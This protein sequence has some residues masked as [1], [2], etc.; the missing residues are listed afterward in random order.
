M[1]T[2]TPDAGDDVFTEE[3]QEVYSQ[4]IR[5]LQNGE[6]ISLG[7]AKKELLRV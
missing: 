1:K 7:K 2:I 5:E 3:D 6:A 4:S